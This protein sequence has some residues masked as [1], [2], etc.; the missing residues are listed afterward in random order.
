MLKI[1]SV[2]IVYLRTMVNVNTKKPGLNIQ[3]NHKMG[4][5][6]TWY[7][8]TLPELI[9]T[10]LEEEFRPLSVHQ[11]WDLLSYGDKYEN[12]QITQGLSIQKIVGAMITNK[13]LFRKSGVTQIGNRA[14]WSIHVPTYKELN[15]QKEAIHVLKSVEDNLDYADLENMDKSEMISLLNEIV[16]LT[17]EARILMGSK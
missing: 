17:I 15:N 11:I 14:L 12:K 4:T 9:Y 7:L 2:T 3:E 1:V 13:H 6:K 5:R 16:A 10:V 8:H